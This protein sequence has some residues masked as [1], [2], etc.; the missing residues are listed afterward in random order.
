MTVPSTA[1][2][3]SLAANGVTTVFPFTFT[4][5]DEEDLKV[6]TVDA[7]GTE[8]VVAAVDYT[9]ALGATGGSVT[10]AV[11]PINGLTVFITNDRDFAQAADIKGQEGYN[12]P[13]NEA[14][15]DSLAILCKQ[16]RA[17]IDRCIKVPETE[18]TGLGITLPA[19]AA[20]ANGYLTFD[21]AGAVSIQASLGGAASYFVVE[22]A[23]VIAQRNGVNAQ[24]FRI[25]ETYTDAANYSRFDVKFAGVQWELFARA[26]GTGTARG[27]RIGT[28]GNQPLRL[29]SNSID[30]W[31][32]DGAGGLYAGLN[33]TYDIGVAGQL[34][35][36]ILW[37]TQA[38]APDGSGATPALARAAQTGTGIYFGANL[39]GFTHSGTIAA[40]MDTGGVRV[41]GSYSIGFT[42]GNG[43]AA[44]DVILARDAANQLALRNGASPQAF[45]LYNTYTNAANN[46]Y[47]QFVWSGNVFVW[48]TQA[49]G[50]GT[51]RSLTLNA[52]GGTLTFQTAGQPRMNI[53]SAGL[54]FNTD[55][56]IDIGASAATRPRSLYWGTQALAPDGTAGSPAISWAN[57]TGFGI[58][59]SGSGA[60]GTYNL[61]IN[62]T[63][64]YQ[65]DNTFFY[66]LGSRGMAFGSAADVQTG[67]D[68]ADVLFLKRGT[69]AQE[70]RIY[71]TTTG[72]KYLSLKHDGTNGLV[73]LTG[74]GV[75]T[76]A[77][78]FNPSTDT[79]R[80][81][82][83]SALRWSLISGININVYASVSD[84][85]P[86]MNVTNGGFQ[87]GPGGSG[88][89]DAG[90]LRVAVNA[91][92]VHH[93]YTSG[94]LTG[95]PAD[96]EHLRLS[97]AVAGAFTVTRF[98]YLKCVQP[99][100]AATIT[101]GA[102]AW[103]DA[104]VGTHKAL[105]SNAAVAVT[106]TS[107]GP[108]G[109][110]TTIQG[111]IKMN[112]NG[113]LRYVP[114]W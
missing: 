57:D 111:W 85:N 13:E 40:T 73:S 29:V 90:H 44:L 105:A 71:G 42:S 63:N 70:F 65:F 3:Q 93:I 109:S 49:N 80:N 94:V 47:A 79:A 25:Y 77:A 81:L 19:A 88:A 89:S 61:S 53:T 33:N 39:I 103:F 31:F 64:C 101:D 35:R 113:T 6:I 4:A 18:T 23:N 74:G 107:V 32:V 72:P 104:A 59:H 8:T 12:P 66:L 45:N 110:Q 102:F 69:N 41:H 96:L 60:T 36:S 7:S 22:A 75:I 97:P 54:M 108:T 98:S 10:F 82:G 2:P 95:S 11:A 16:N 14:A 15:M 99:T 83:T 56:T 43:A 21:A 17:S 84:A 30:R 38:L 76:T 50:T 9:V 114:F 24:E 112:I 87:L 52:S 55:N 5:L 78:D 46:E 106:I 27:M 91:Q 51:F 62:S 86:T 92:P 100:G 68:A 28:T 26:A 67:R 58:F 48:Q 37:G 20:R 1:F 34:P